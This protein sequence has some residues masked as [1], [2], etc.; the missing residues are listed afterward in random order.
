MGA[1]PVNT[2]RDEGSARPDGVGVR[3]ALVALG[4]L[5]LIAPAAFYAEI[6]YS[7]H[8]AGVLR[9]SSGA[10]AMAPLVILFL[11]TAAMHLP[12]LRARGLSRKELLAVYSV[13]LV[14]APLA[15]SFTLF[16]MLSR[17]IGLY[18]GAQARTGWQVALPY[19]PEWFAPSDLGAVQG[20]FEGGRAVPWSLWALPLAAWLSFITCLCAASL[21]MMLMFQRQW[22]RH[23]RLTFPIAEIPIHM[24]S[25]PEGRRHTAGRLPGSRA[26]WVGLSLTFA[27][28]S[29]NSLAN[30]FP[31]LPQIPMQVTILSW[32]GV[33]P[34]AGLGDLRVLFVPHLIGITYLMPIE[35]SF[36]CWFFYFV[37][38]GLT[39]LAIARGSAP[40]RPDQ[41]WGAE[42]PAPYYQGAGTVI[43][44]ALWVIWAGR[45]HLARGCRGA[46]GLSG[47]VGDQWVWRYATLT[48]AISVL[49][50]VWLCWAAG[51]RVWFAFL[52]IAGVLGYYLVW[53]RLRAETGLGFMTFPAPLYDAAVSFGTGRLRPEELVTLTAIYW[54]YWP[55]QAE[56]YDSV[57]QNSIDAFKVADA[58]RVDLRSLVWLMIGGMALMVGLGT[59]VMLTGTYHYGFYE[60]KM[61]RDLISQF[62]IWEGDLL[63]QWLMQP[64][65]PDAAAIPAVGAGGLVALALTF[66]RLRLAWWPFHTL[67]YLAGNSWAMHLI[68]G[69]FFL[70]WLL[71]LLTVRYGGLHLYRKA[72]PLAIGIVVGEM[73][74][75]GVWAAI[76]LATRGRVIT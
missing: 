59:F 12:W 11:L 26:F 33:G 63:T 65:R 39:V 42:F 50:M 24:V 25:Q 73:L 49:L 20:F 66:L 19:I 28:T 68:W 5:A 48:L 74:Q 45:R 10:P 58:S 7:S 55:G 6:A 40:R 67:G 56:C 54:T 53:A 27:V 62:L 75:V 57:A 23:D 15:G 71:K 8:L 47:E 64:T 32:V 76:I 34:L 9:F 61:G 4:V 51:C 41:W 31:A 35:L 36:S 37:R 30:R 1:G 70:G 46:L 43:F 17:V 13:V 29:W 21:S 18:W 14:A 2:R 38:L 22:I 72:I 60:L 69:P 3:A 16:H 52:L 44:L